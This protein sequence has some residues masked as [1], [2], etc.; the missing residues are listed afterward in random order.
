MAEAWKREIVI[1]IPKNQTP[2]DYN[3]LR[4]ISMS[5]LWS[6]LLESIVSEIT[7]Q[8]TKKNWKSNQHGGIKGS[9]TDHILVKAWDR[10]LRALD[11]SSSNK[12]VVFT[13]IDFSKSFSRC[14]YQ[15]ILQAY[16]EVGASNWL[17]K[18]HAAFLTDRSMRVKIGNV[19]S[20]NRQV[21]GGA[22]QGSILGVLDHNAVLETI[23]GTNETQAEKYVDD[24]TLFE[25]IP[26]AR[27][28]YID[29]NNKVS[30]QARGC[31]QS[32]EEIED[33]CEMKGLKINDKKTQLLALSSV[34]PVER[35]VWVGLNDGSQ[36]RG[37]ENLKLLGFQFSNNLNCNA[38]VSY[39][40]RRAMKRAYVLRHYAKFLPGSD[41]LKLYKS[42][43]RSVLEYSS[44][45][46]TTQ[47]CKYQINRLENVQKRCLKIMF[48]YKKNYQELLEESGLE[49]LQ[50]RR[51]KALL[52]FAQKTSKNELYKDYFPLNESTTVT[53]NPKIF[54]EM[55]ARTD[56]LYNSPIFAMR[57][58]LNNTPYHDRFNN[59]NYVN[60][61][62]LFN[63]PFY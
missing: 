36:I 44:V 29:D 15:Q 34:K 47:I 53:R 17:L 59:P 30:Y 20:E 19:I 32:L 57:R 9:S 25:S 39:L 3:D 8:E 41:L 22:V 13:A 35:N 63:D 1:A 45:S 18:M 23:R 16:V 58:A 10:I 48:G 28:G 54:K 42:L 4:P 49:T 5:P 56:R 2:R 50:A 7:L 11:K 21:T 26:P 14:S 38:Q 43:I 37:S 6:K 52:K 60:L 61:A 24:L 40:I 12:A 62:G 27:P 51:T 31:E 46:Y 33:M 55:F